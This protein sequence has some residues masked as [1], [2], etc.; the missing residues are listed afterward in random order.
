MTA[1]KLIVTIALGL[2][3][4]V[5]VRY[6]TGFAQTSTAGLQSGTLLLTETPSTVITLVPPFKF[7]LTDVVV[8][9]LENASSVQIMDGDTV[10]LF[11]SAPQVRFT[12]HQSFVNGIV[13]TE[14]LSARCFDCE[15]SGPVLTV[16][17]RIVKK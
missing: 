2:I 8:P 11:I 17:G 7:I 10:R 9:F 1:H 5:G 4:V 13:F 12:H 16:S 3:W 14:N 15:S 6:Q